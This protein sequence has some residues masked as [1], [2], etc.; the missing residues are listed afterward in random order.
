MLGGTNDVTP[1]GGVCNIGG[2][3]ASFMVIGG[4]G[5]KIGRQDGERELFVWRGA[6]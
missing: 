5:S 4:P 6:I 2:R 3:E 1:K